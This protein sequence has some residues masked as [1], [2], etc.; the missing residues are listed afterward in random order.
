V[1]A[2][3]REDASRTRP[4]VLAAAGDQID[5]DA[6][7]G[8]AHAVTL[9]GPHDVRET[10]QLLRHRAG[11][12]LPVPDT[13]GRVLLDVQQVLPLPEAADF[14]MQ[15]R[16]REAERRRARRVQS[17]DLTRSHIVVD[18]QILPT[19]PSATRSASWLSNSSP[20]ACP[21]RPSIRSWPVQDL[22]HRGRLR[23]PRRPDRDM[24]VDSQAAGYPSNGQPR[25][26][27]RPV[28][29]IRWGCR[30]APN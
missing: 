21:C 11:A 27:H 4:V 18:G 10:E 17:R 13:D 23:R 30:F 29:V 16:R 22:D 19:R 25:T 14:Q 3:G 2:C 28:P 9:P 15:L 7:P 5:A 20:E 6:Q 24:Q 12:G 8:S 26:R 1:G